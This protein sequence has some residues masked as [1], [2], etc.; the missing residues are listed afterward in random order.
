MSAQPIGYDDSGDPQQR[1]DPQRTLAVLTTDRQ[2]EVF[3]AEYREAARAAIDPAGW[4]KLNEMLTRW[5]LRAIAYS[6]PG[7]AADQADAAADRGTYVGLEEILRR[8]A[9][10]D[11]R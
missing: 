9:E 1:I 4:A 10:L 8:R 6:R 5:S 7:F 11:T 2:R 3:L